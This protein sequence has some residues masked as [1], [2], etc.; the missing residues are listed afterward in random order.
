MAHQL[1]SV[2]GVMPVPVET[3]AKAVVGTIVSSVTRIS[4]KDVI[5]FL[6]DLM[7]TV[8]FLKFGTKK[9]TA[10]HEQSALHKGLFT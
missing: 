10:H 2:V 6:N 9:Q 7:H 4:S 5:R 3:A 1:S 8:P